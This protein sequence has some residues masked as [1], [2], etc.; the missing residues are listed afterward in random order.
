MTGSAGSQGLISLGTMTH[1]TEVSRFLEQRREHDFGLHDSQGRALGA[2]IDLLTVEVSGDRSRGNST[3][4]GG[5]RHAFEGRLIRDGEPFGSGRSLLTYFETSEERDA[6]VRE[7]LYYARRRINQRI[8]A[9]HRVAMRASHAARRAVS[10]EKRKTN[11]AVR[12]EAAALVAAALIARLK[13]RSFE[14]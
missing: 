10:Y 3:P 2:R 8:K 7:Y 13:V 14:G 12:E 9:E 4:S 6:K 11:R 5:V 1:I